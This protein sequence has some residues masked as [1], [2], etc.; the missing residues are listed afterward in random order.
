MMTRRS[1]PSTRSRK[2]RR[3]LVDQAKEYREKI[4]DAVV[5]FDEQAM[6]RYL[7]GDTLE[8]KRSSGQFVQDDL[9]EDDSCFLRFGF[10][11]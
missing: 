9:H 5:E 11:E 7:N 2:F 3:I 4:L 6:E 1:A 8:K 10:Q